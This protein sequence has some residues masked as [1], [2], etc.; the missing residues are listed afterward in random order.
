[1]NS[2][3]QNYERNLQQYYQWHAPFYDATRWS[4]LFGRQSLINNL[5]ALP[6]S[7]RILEIGCGT[8]VN[9]ERLKATY[10]DARITGLDISAEMLKCATR[11]LGDAAHI[12][13]KNQKYGLSNEFHAPFDLVLLSYSLTMMGNEMELVIRRVSHDLAPNGCIAVVDF[14]DTSSRF[15]RRWMNKN[16]VTMDGSL[17]AILEKNFAPVDVTINSAWFGLWSYMQFIGKR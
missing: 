14:H 4:F 7:P 2:S 17:L 5:P 6:S 13:L 16:H 9:L 3:T 12:T 11:R 8:G 15:F 10:R 1:M